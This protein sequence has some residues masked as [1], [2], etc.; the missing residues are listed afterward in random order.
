MEIKKDSFAIIEY[1]LQLE[2]GFFVRGENGPAS[3][4]FV[5]GYNQL[6]PAL[7]RRLLGHCAG[8]ELRFVIP[9]REAFG[10]YDETQVHR[11]TFDEFPQGRSLKVGKWVRAADSTTG[12]QYQYHVKE[13]NEDGI[14]LDFNHP[15]AG[16]DL[17]YHVKII[18][19]R[20]AL[21]EELEFLRPCEHAGEASPQAGG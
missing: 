19:V 7:E 21:A 2:D 4:N 18:F 16:K 13:K 10:E 12:A 17:Y 8:E 9:A 11:H 5:A 6:L 3:L 15:L 14:L 1:T 20:P